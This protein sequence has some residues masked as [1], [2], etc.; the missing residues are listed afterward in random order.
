MEVE[1]VA[2]VL[3]TTGVEAR[4]LLVMGPGLVEIVITRARPV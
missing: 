1:G 2:V 4:L 3:T